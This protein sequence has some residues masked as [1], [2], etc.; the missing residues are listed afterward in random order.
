MGKEKVRIIFRNFTVEYFP[1]PVM[2]IVQMKISEK[3]RVEKLQQLLGKVDLR[4]MKNDS[5]FRLIFLFFQLDAIS[6]RNQQKNEMIY[7]TESLISIPNAILSRD[8]KLSW[9][10]QQQMIGH[11][12]SLEYSSTSRSPSKFDEVRSNSL[13]NE[14]IS[15]VKSTSIYFFSIDFV[16]FRSAEN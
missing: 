1:V 11:E 10:A 16:T 3:E 15:K 13:R 6:M 9:D 12:L 7:P 5:I 2:D 14:R 8:L 4:R